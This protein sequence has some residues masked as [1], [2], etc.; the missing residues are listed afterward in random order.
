MS[1]LKQVHW[2]CVVVVSIC[3]LLTPSFAIAAPK[4]MDAATVRARV[5][6]RGIDR[7][8]AVKDKTGLE[9]VGRIIAIGDVGFTIQLPNDPQPTE[10]AYADVIDLRTGYTSGEKT[11]IFA[12]LAGA[13]GFGIWAAVH[14][15]NVSSQHQLP[16]PPTQPVFP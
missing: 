16:N 6:K 14:F 1:A 9:L 12:S 4:P 11:F 2:R 3:A 15:H 7:W 13:A 5:E 10:I 8:I